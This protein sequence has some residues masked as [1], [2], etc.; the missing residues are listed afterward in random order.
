MSRLPVLILLMLVALITESVSAGPPIARFQ[1]VLGNFDVLLDAA[2]KPISVRNFT[3]Y[4]NR[5]AYDT[6]IIHRSTTKN[7]TDIQIVQGGGFELVSNILVPVTTD[8]P[9]L[10][11]AGMSN[12][13]GTLAMART[14]DP[15]SA[16]SQWYFNVA[17]NTRL[18]FDYAVFGQ[19]LG[20]GQ[21]V[22]D[23]I[24]A[25]PTYDKRLQLQDGAFGQLPLFGPDLFIQNLVFIN[26]VR[27]ETFAITNVT[28]TA[29][30]TELRWTA[31]STNTPVRV[32]RTTDLVT[33]PWT[34]LATNLTTGAFTDTNAPARG[35]F[36]RLI[37]E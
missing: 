18:D 26:S 19:T 25:V 6:T 23:A 22:L 37:T 15:N 32:E 35:A 29:N 1:S 14:P 9:I 2:T 20:G 28:R 33:G 12:L 27:V 21:G 7:P 16:T 3:A 36:Y 30:I 17:N 24:G 4:A 10:L 34:P 11:E 8:S 5:G 13:R 31:L